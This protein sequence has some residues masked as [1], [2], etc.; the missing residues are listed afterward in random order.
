MPITPFLRLHG[1]RRPRAALF[2]SGGGSN[3]ERLIEDLAAA[4]QTASYEVALLV[5][6]APASSRAREIGAN[7]GIP[8]VANDIRAFYREQGEARVTLATARG[9]ELRDQW[10]GQLRGQIA[11]F[12]VDFGVLAGF[13]PL[14]NITGDFPCLNVHPG[15]LT[16]LRNGRRYLVGLHTVPIERAILAGLNHLR[17]SVIVA[18]PYTGHGEDMDNGPLLGISEPVPIDLHGNTIEELR[19]VAGARPAQRP[20][21][22]YGDRLDEVAKLNQDRL[23]REGDWVVLPKA[24]RAFALGDYGTDE[25]GQLC[26][27]TGGTWQPIETIVFGRDREEPLFRDTPR[28]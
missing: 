21:G 18:L 26:L 5:T 11:P 4:G 3:A 16:Y 1:E 27:R 12:R 19:A 24:V 13:V 2:L 20:P 28:G 23:K 6:D 17:S 15:D 10:T 25:S 9:R 7:F 22:G 14:T 8:V